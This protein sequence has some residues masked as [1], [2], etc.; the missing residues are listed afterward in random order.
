[1]SFTTGATTLLGLLADILV[2]IL[3]IIVLLDIL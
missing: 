3:L 2:N 1:L